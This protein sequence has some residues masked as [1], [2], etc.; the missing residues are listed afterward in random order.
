[1]ASP[2]EGP[3]TQFVGSLLWSELRSNETQPAHFHWMPLPVSPADVPAPADTPALADT[4]PADAS[5]S[6]ST[7]PSRRS[8]PE[9]TPGFSVPPDLASWRQRLFQFNEGEIITLSSEQ[10]NQYWPFMTNVWTKHAAPYVTKRKRTIRIQWDCRFHK[11]N[12]PN[13]LGSGQRG[14]QIRIPTSCPAKL[15][16]HHDLESDSRD[17]TMTNSHNHSITELD[18]TKI[19]TGVQSWVEGQLLQGFPCTAIEKVAKGKGNGASA[20]QNLHDAGGR[21]LSVKYIRNAANRLKIRAPTPRHVPGNV[22]TE[23]Q[24]REALEWLR[25]RGDDWYSAFLETSYKGSPSRGLVFGR[26]TTIEVLRLRGLLTLMDSTH[27]T[28]KAGW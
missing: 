9:V 16:E 25:V 17:F 19:N 24:A 2:A 26:K 20:P 1:M 21:Y 3:D 18:M 12:A 22:S 5:G 10:W 13:S 27:N 15:F 23:S 28:N 4:P 6:S 7:T 8:T 14:K 11:K